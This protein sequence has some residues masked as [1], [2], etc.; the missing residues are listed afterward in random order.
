[1]R[2][3]ERFFERRKENGRS[4]RSAARGSGQITQLHCPSANWPWM[5][6]SRSLIYI[7]ENKRF[8]ALESQLGPQGENGTMT[9]GLFIR[10][11]SMCDSKLY[12]SPIQWWSR[13]CSQGINGPIIPNCQGRYHYR[14]NYPHPRHCWDQDRVRVDRFHKMLLR[15]PLASHK[16]LESHVV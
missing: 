3:L 11:K 14:P 6:T 13:V 15:N 7:F 9:I 2:A 8:Q 10:S 16:R 4:Y 5:V 12:H 1:V